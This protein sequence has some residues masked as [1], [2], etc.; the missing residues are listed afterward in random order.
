MILDP[1]RIRKAL[2]L[3][4]LDTIAD[5]ARW[6]ADTI[7]GIDKHTIHLWRTSALSNEWAV[8]DDPNEADVSVVE[9]AALGLGDTEQ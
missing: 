7:E 5:A 3:G 4:D 9:L 1:A 2:E 6:A 8:T